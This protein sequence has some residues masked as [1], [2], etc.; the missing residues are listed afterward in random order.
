MK[1][2]KNPLT[3]VGVFSGLAEIAGTTVL[4]L[5]SSALQSVFIWYVMVFPVVLI[6]FFF[7]TWNFNPAVLYPP[8]EYKDQ[9]DYKELITRNVA[10]Q[11][12]NMEDLKKELEDIIKKTVNDSME[13]MDNDHLD[14]DAINHILDKNIVMVNEKID[15]AKLSM[16]NM[17]V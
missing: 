6:I 17:L 9:K 16:E 4:P 8:G 10:A 15:R 7:L 3:V 2:I 12:K 13:N 11:Q 5:L 1:T 14:Q